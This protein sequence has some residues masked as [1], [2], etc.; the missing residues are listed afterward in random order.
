MNGTLATRTLTIAAGGTLRGTG[1]IDAP[2]TVGGTLRPGNSPGTLTFTQSV[3]QSATGTLMLDIDG[4][5]TGSGAFGNYSRVVVTGIGSY[6]AGG[7]LAPVLRGITGSANNTFTPTL[8]Q[9]FTVV[10]AA[11]GVTGNFASLVQPSTGLGAGTRFDVSYGANTIDLFVTPA[12]FAN[13][14]ALGGVV[15]RNRA[16]VG[17]ALD[18]LRG[19]AGPALTG[20]TAA[21]INALYGL[22]VG[23]MGAAL[24]QMAGTVH[25]DAMTAALSANRM[26][27]FS[28]G[29]WDGSPTMTALH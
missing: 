20:D 7:A 14:S 8:G 22:P 17:G 23:G 9:R 1:T 25:G 6:T 12:S 10:T 4:T 16:A 27:A 24:D 19:P 18:V 28:D 26:F 11:G 21:V 5:G 3:V 15:T 29:N 2:A 13:L